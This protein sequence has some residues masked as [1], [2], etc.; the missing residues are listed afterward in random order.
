MLLV[1]T[2]AIVRPQHRVSPL[3][4]IS[5]H[6]AGIPAHLHTLVESAFLC[7]LADAF[8]GLRAVLVEA[9]QEHLVSLHDAAAP[10]NQRGADENGDEM[11]HFSDSFAVKCPLICKGRGDFRLRA[12]AAQLV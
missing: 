8:V 1:Q 11:F 7:G 5:R 4:G 3:V 2:M 6:F 9:R 10:A 12:F